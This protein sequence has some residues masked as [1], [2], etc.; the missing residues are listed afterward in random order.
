MLSCRL[1]C[2]YLRTNVAGG[3]NMLVGSVLCG[4]ALGCLACIYK[5]SINQ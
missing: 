4:A 3:L 2:E 1:A 5:L